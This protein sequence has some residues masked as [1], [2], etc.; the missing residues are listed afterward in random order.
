MDAPNFCANQGG[1]SK[2]IFMRLVRLRAPGGLEN[3]KMAFSCVCGSSHGRS[4]HRVHR[5]CR[6]S[7]E[8][9]TICRSAQVPPWKGC[10]ALFL[11]MIAE[12]AD[13]RCSTLLLP[14]NGQSTSP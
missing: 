12:K 14:Q 4:R 8:N 5:C 3:L 6:R 9:R 13:Q 10:Y 1:G 7:G 11:D 2:G